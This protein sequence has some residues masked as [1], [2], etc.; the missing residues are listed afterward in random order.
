MASTVSAESLSS[1]R[2]RLEMRPA[3]AKASLKKLETCWREQVGRALARAFS[4]AGFSQKEVSALLGHRD[5]SQINRWIAGTERPQ[6]DALFAVE[7]LRQPMVI[8]LAELAGDSVEVTTHI[9]VRRT[10]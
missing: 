1:P 7:R 9:T 2:E 5:Q 10:A 6:F 4:L 3:M 8:A